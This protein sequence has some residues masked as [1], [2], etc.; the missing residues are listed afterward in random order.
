MGEV[1]RKC[2]TCIFKGTNYDKGKCTTCHET[3]NYSNYKSAFISIEKASAMQREIDAL[4]ASYTEGCLL[5][6][7]PDRYK[8]EQPRIDDCIRGMLARIEK[9]RELIR[10]RSKRTS[11]LGNEIQDLKRANDALD[12][13]YCFIIEELK[14]ALEKLE[15]Q[16]EKLVDV[17]HGLVVGDK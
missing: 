2:E 8:G 4:R 11:E 3:E 12:E 17:L 10:E 15:T 14:T 13:H 7:I 6:M 1:E 9:Q 5:D 16:N